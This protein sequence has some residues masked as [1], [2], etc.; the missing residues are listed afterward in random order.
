VKFVAHPGNLAGGV[1]GVS[2]LRKQMELK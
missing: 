2:I 1:F